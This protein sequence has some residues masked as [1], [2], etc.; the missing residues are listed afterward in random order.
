MEGAKNALIEDVLTRYDALMLQCQD[1]INEQ[2]AQ[3]A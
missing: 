3:T 2:N 1:L